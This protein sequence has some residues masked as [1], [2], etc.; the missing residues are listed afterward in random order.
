MAKARQC[1]RCN[2]LYPCYNLVDNELE[3]NAIIF[4]SLLEDNKYYGRKCLDLCP[5][6][7]EDIKKWFKEKGNNINRE[8]IVEV[9]LNDDN[10]K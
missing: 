10:V 8:S 6:C 2:N 5:N 9:E 4:T 7:M 3:P 1:D